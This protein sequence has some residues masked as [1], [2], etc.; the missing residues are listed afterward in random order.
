MPASWRERPVRNIKGHLNPAFPL[1]TVGVQR[2]SM[3]TTH[4]TGDV[5]Q[6]ER[7]PQ[8]NAQQG[9][10]Q[11][12]V[13]TLRASRS[14]KGIAATLKATAGASRLEQQQ[15]QQREQEERARKEELKRM[16]PK[17]FPKRPPF[18]RMKTW[19]GESITQD[20]G[21]SLDEVRALPRFPTTD[22][23]GR[24]I[25]ALKIVITA[26]PSAAAAA[27]GPSNTRQKGK[28]SNSTA[29]KTGK[30]RAREPDENPPVKSSSSAKSAEIAKAA[31]AQNG[32]TNAQ[33]EPP[34]MRPRR[35]AERAAR[36]KK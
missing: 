33:Q 15:Q 17:H 14:T 36:A 11:K 12:A 6:P 13:K 4:E 23:P 5:G 26:T 32:T 24:R 30:K 35:N 28:D 19:A 21:I 20:S 25:D 29:A 16:L 31:T 34:A 1:Q 7:P 2:L 9:P 22:R 10:P 3:Q 18:R 27:A 8:P